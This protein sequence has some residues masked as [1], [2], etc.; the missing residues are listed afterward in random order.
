MARPNTENFSYGVSFALANGNGL[1][2][3][4]GVGNAVLQFDASSDFIWYQAS[5]SANNNAAN[6]G[7]A[8][9]T[10]QYPPITV[11]L[12]PGDTSANM[13]NQAVPVTHIFGN[14]EMPFVLPAPRVIPARTTLAIAVTNLDTTIAYDLYLTFIGVKRFLSAP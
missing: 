6:T 13:M 10:R 1:A 14:G 5:Y 8:E 9:A 11:L 2:A 4:G 7:W 12:T 3:A